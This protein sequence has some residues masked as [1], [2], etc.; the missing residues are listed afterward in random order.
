MQPRQ[1]AL[2]LAL[3]EPEVVQIT[4]AQYRRAVDLLAAMIVDAVSWSEPTHQITIKSW[5]LTD[6]LCWC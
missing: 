2:N 5:R 3:T 6:T 1:R 4:P